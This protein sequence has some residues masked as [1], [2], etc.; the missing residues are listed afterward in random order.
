M[1]QGSLFTK[2][3]DSR[4]MSIILSNDTTT[5]VAFTGHIKKQ[6]SGGKWFPEQ[7]RG[8]RICLQPRPSRASRKRRLKR[9]KGFFA[10]LSKQ[11]TGLQQSLSLHAVPKLPNYPPPLS[12]VL[13][14]Q[15]LFLAIVCFHREIQR[16]SCTVCRGLSR[17]GL[18]PVGSTRLLTGPLR[19]F[20]R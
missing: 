20:T 3:Q 7:A 5:S 15:H 1:N 12:L 6:Q 4:V 8:Q 10:S 17:A 16:S 14:V 13:C 18:G 2:Y 11:R 9:G 19:P